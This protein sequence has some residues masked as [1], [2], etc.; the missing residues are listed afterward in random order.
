MKK[1]ITTLLTMTLL[2]TSVIAPSRPQYMEASSNNYMKSLNLKW[3][4]KKNK[5]VTLTAN[6]PGIG[7]KKFNVKMTTYKIENAADDKYNKLTV[8]YTVTR[9][10]TPTKKQV[11]KIL[12][13]CYVKLQKDYAYVPFVNGYAVVDY[14]TGVSLEG[15]N[16]FDVT[17]KTLKNK[18]S[19]TKKFKCKNGWIKLAKTATV[20]FQVTY[21]KDYTGLSIGL[22]G[23]NA[24]YGKTIRVQEDRSIGVTD[25]DAT[26]FEATKLSKV[27]K[28]L[29]RED[30]EGTPFRYGD[31]SYYLKGKKNSHWLRVN[32]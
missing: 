28:N 27:K 30:E 21:P 18:S 3:D 7:H 24:E 5:N 2:I 15:K 32:P 16:D 13:T 8:G 9:K 29:Y 10:W 11:D 31:T 14:N 19:G 20:K 4:L 1:I 22:L 17:V 23:R 12:K 6:Y 26:F 25:V